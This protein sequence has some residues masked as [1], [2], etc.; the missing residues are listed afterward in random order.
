MSATYTDAPLTRTDKTQGLRSLT[1]RLTRAR[2]QAQAGESL[3]Y[4]AGILAYTVASALALTVAGGT[5]MFWMRRIH[6]SPY[7]QRL[8]AADESFLG[9]LDVYCFLALLACALLLPALVNLASGAALLG[10]RG[11]E[12]RLAALRLLGLSSGDVTRMALLDS[13]IQSLVGIA[14]GSLIYLITLPLWHNLT[15][16]AVR[17]GPGEMLVPWWLFLTVAVAV[18]LLGLLA[19]VR[20]L[21]LVHISP[22]GV[23]RRAN[24]PKL[25]WA[26][27]IVFL[28]LFTVALIMTA[29]L[30]LGSELLP[31]LILAGGVV[32]LMMGLNVLGP[33]LLQLMARISAHLP[34]PTIKWA[35]RR[36][37]ADP[38]ATWHRV[39]GVGLL[40]FIGGFM[41]LAPLE[42]AGDE[43]GADDIVNQ[44]LRTARWDFS[45]GVVITLAAGFLLTATSLL[46]TQAS[47]TIE[48]SP[49]SQALRR[50]GSPAGFSLRVMWLETYVPLVLAV[51]AGTA[52]GMVLSLPILQAQLRLGMEPEFSL[53]LI[54]TVTGAGLVVAALALLAT[55]PLYHRLLG[56]QRRR[57][58]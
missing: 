31:Y 1:L 7:H 18:M 8:L 15:M 32:M 12:Q 30:R 55:H 27:V 54:S 41:A 56:E 47:N 42:L 11:R 58:D 14:A 28:A 57:N 35:S 19:T 17:V 6:P 2:F 20:G 36:I 52:L 16:M 44:F 48:R 43:T 33:W 23:A 50:M 13:L 53:G 37:A 26:R 21:R 38:K 29:G 25:T 5:W 39:A 51:V 46:I 49:Q 22:L 9:L 45:V 3:L 10:A 4:F 24:K 40:S 34:S